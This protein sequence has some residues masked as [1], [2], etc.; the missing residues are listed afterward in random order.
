M[1]NTRSAAGRSWHLVK[2][3]SAHTAEPAI[4]VVAPRSAPV[5]SA[6]KVVD[7][8]SLAVRMEIQACHAQSYV[9]LRTWHLVRPLVRPTCPE[10]P[11]RHIE[12]GGLR[13]SYSHRAGGRLTPCSAA[14]LI[15]L[16]VIHVVVRGTAMKI[17]PSKP[18]W[19]ES[20]RTSGILTPVVHLLVIDYIAIHKLQIG[21]FAASSCHVALGVVAPSPAPI[22][23]ALK[24]VHILVGSSTQNVNPA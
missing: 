22:V 9:P 14:K 21:R 12:V 19:D 23:V 11:D 24:I 3:L 5:I 6:L 16:K 18:D 15:A 7:V 20:R 1:H 2:S 17:D 13:T 8:R 4:G 10:G